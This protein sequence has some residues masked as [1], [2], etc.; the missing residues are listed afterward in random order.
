MNLGDWERVKR[1]AIELADEHAYNRLK[2][3]VS[4]LVD[5]LIIESDQKEPF[6]KEKVN[7]DIP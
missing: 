4:D 5:N 6:N 3:F 1:A 2:F 7:L